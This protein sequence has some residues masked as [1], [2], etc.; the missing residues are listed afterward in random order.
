MV[1]ALSSILSAKGIPWNI[2]RSVRGRIPDLTFDLDGREFV[3]E[4]EV[5]DLDRKSRV[6]GKM[7]SYA[8]RDVVFLCDTGRV[9]DLCSIL[10]RPVEVREKSGLWLE[11]PAV[12]EGR[13]IRFRDL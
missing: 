7:A 13:E 6:V 2:G 3:V 9:Q 1:R 5:S 12:L 11:I 8:G 10:E 4:V